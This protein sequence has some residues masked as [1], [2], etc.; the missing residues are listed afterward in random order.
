MNLERSKVS[1]LHVNHVKSGS[2]GNS[3]VDNG[4]IVGLDD[5][6]LII[7]AEKLGE[8]WTEV[9]DGFWA[10]NYVI[11]LPDFSHSPKNKWFRVIILN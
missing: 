6:V 2:L 11:M 1:G 7:M 10:S 3:M 8:A 4:G 9:Y 5:N